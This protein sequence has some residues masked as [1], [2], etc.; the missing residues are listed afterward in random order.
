[1][2]IHSVW[3]DRFGRWTTRAGGILS[4][5]LLL[6]VLP[7]CLSLSRNVS[8]TEDLKPLEIR[9]VKPASVFGDHMVLQRDMRIP[10]WGTA[11]AGETVTVAF[12]A[13]KKTVTADTEGK[14]IVRLDAVEAGGPFE[15]TIAGKNTITFKDVYVGEVWL[16]S[17]QSNMDMTVAKEDRY[18]CGV[19]NEAQEVAA[20]DYPLIR[21][22]DV[23]F[24]P[25][26]EPQSDAKG[27]WE[28]CSPKTVGHFSAAAY[29]FARQLQKKLNAPIGLVTTAYGASTAEAWTSRSALAAKPTTAFLLEEYKKRCQNYDSGWEQ[30]NYRQDLAEWQ[31][32]SEKAKVDNKRTPKKPGKPKNPHQDQHSPCVLYNGMVAPLIPYA[33]RGAIWYQ[34]ESNGPTAKIY[35]K[36]METLI[37][38]WRRAWGEGSFPFLYVQLA[39]YSKN[40]ETFMIRE[41]QLK[42]LSIPNTAMVVTIDIGDADNIHPKNKQDVGLRLS[43]AAR[44]LA[45]GESIPY[46]GPIYDSMSVEG[47]SIRLRFKHIDGGLVA[48]GGE[49]KGFTIAGEDKKFI[50]A[51]AKID[52]DTIVVSISETAKPVA[53]RYGFDNN[54]QVSLYNKADLPASP[55]RTD[56][57]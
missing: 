36:I 12:N 32:A 51:D 50:P 44:A 53:V 15:M 47:N 2:F 33:I 25:K 49:L 10:V 48:K 46:M 37:Q 56:N 35:D 29:F 30:I 13:Q 34:G 40:R 41:G 9:Q 45:Y 38:D 7:G 57:F 22:F 18:W 20:A 4:L 26:D 42:N 43:L 3:H 6:C 28:I 54:P 21:V 14:W 19:N 55:F 8:K 31:R 52:G 11:D 24:A 39:N 5:A 27:V 23:E 16:C 1:M 17:G